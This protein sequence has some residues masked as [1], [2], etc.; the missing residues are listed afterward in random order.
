MLTRK[1]F[2]GECASLRFVLRAQKALEESEF[3][4]VTVKKVREMRRLM[5]QFMLEV[6]AM[7]RPR[8]PPGKISLS[9]SQGTGRQGRV[10]GGQQNEQKAIEA[11]G[12]LADLCPSPTWSVVGEQGHVLLQDEGGESVLSLHI[13][14]SE[15]GFRRNTERAWQWSLEVGG[16]T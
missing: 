11:E 16:G 6:R 7:A 15:K 2:S 1:C 10:G 9:T 4:P 13:Q 14:P 3:L 8:I 12:Q 5:P